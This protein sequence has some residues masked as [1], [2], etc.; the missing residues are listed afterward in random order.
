MIAD[1]MVNT[2][3]VSW[4]AAYI[5]SPIIPETTGVINGK[6]AGAQVYSAHEAGRAVQ[7]VLLLFSISPRLWSIRAMDTAFFRHRYERITAD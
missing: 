3:G 1:Q 7:I 5:E 6:L 4:C 2:F